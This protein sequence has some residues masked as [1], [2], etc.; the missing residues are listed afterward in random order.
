MGHISVN[1]AGLSVAAVLAGW[2][3]AWILLAASGWAQPLVE[4]VYRLHFLKSEAVVGPFD[5]ATGA[6]L[7]MVAAAVGYAAG[8]TLALA[9]NC[10]G[11]WGESAAVSRQ[12]PLR[13]RPSTPARAS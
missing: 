10:L 11:W 4:F 3:L 8:A 7:V 6:L 1:R 12:E 13:S 5:P 2:H 9:W